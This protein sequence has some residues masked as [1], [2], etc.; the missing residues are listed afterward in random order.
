LDNYFY[1]KNYTITKED[2]DNEYHHLHHVR[3]VKLLETVRIDWFNEKLFS[4]EELLIKG[5]LC[6][7]TKLDLDFLREIKEGEVA[8]VLSNLKLE[9]KKIILTQKLYN[10]K[11]KCLVS[12][13][14][15]LVFIDITTKRGSVPPKGF[16]NKIKGY[17]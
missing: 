15:N 6:V 1:L 14:V 7:I 17:I 3:I 16:L 9:N 8:G 13:V 10:N 2:I 12:A 4:L 11:K 5:F